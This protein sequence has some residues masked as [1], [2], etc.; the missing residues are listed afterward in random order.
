MFTG[1]IPV[2]G[3]AIAAALLASTAAPAAAAPA[4]DDI[5]DARAIGV[6]RTIQGTINDATKQRGEP[7]HANSLATRS[8]WYRF[9]TQRRVA[10]GLSTC[11]SDFDTVLAVYTGRSLR[12]LRAVEFNNDGCGAG[13]GSR[14]TF[15]AR[16]GRV[17]RIAVAGFAPRGRFRLR[18]ERVDVPPNDDFADA[19]RIGLGETIAA[20]T[21]NATRELGEPGHAFNEPHTI[22]FR[23]SV[24]APT[25]VR[26]SNCAA[27][28]SHGHVTVYTGASVR[29]LTRVAGDDD[30]ATEFQA[31]PGAV[32]RIVVEDA[33]GAAVRLAAQAVS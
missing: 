13:G 6:G 29:T 31:L 5:G 32:Y 4:N 25:I 11:S 1:K 33:A 27:N 28:P 2:S 7:R 19:V 3:L 24:A 8:V 12:S 17:Y 16:P 30:C 14:V 15:T 23:L 26:V 20:T 21:R 9:R 10:L 22:W 18:T